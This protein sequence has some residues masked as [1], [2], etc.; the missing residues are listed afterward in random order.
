MMCVRVVLH[1]RAGSENSPSARG[2]PTTAQQTAAAAA[3]RT[4]RVPTLHINIAMVLLL[5]IQPYFWRAMKSCFV[6]GGFKRSLPNSALRHRSDRPKKQSIALHKL[7]R[8]Q[9]GHFS[10][11]SKLRSPEIKKCRTFPKCNVFPDSGNIS[12]IDGSN[13]KWHQ[14]AHEGYR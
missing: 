12:E 5:F 6:R 8:S 10:F 13:S 1:R 9:A 14:R 4:A 7:Q 3:T 2:Q 11:R